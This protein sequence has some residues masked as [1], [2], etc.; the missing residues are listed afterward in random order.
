MGTAKYEKLYYK[1]KDHPDTA[2]TGNKSGF[3]SKFKTKER[4]LAKQWISNQEAYSLHKPIKK[5]FKRSKTVVSGIDSQYQ[6]DLS[7]VSHISKENDQNRYLLCILD[8]LSR[9]AWVIPIKNKKGETVA[10]TFRALFKQENR[11]CSTLLTD[12]GAE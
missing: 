7:D 11:H 1:L 10:A 2:F 4:K 5:R 6:A 3:A 12:L 9:Y 8:T